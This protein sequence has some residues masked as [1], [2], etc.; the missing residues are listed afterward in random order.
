MVSEIDIMD[1]L[2]PIF[3]IRKFKCGRKGMYHDG[4]YIIDS[5]LGVVK[6]ECCDKELNPI[7]LLRQMA[8]TESRY[9]NRFSQYKKII[10]ECE[11]KI[12]TKCDHCGKQT[13]IKTK[14]KVWH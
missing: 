2:A 8:Q 13:R 7:E 11:K 4:P 5:T 12:R 9:K 6:C 3:E 1:D 10:A 14:S